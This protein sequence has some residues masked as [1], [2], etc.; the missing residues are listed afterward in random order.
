MEVIQLGSFTLQWSMLVLLVS[1]VFGIVAIALRLKMENVP[2]KPWTEWAGTILVCILLNEK[3]GYLWDSPSIIWNQTKAL[4]FLSGTSVNGNVLLGIGL[5][6]WTITYIR[7]HQLSYGLLSDVA[8]HGLLMGLAVYGFM[9][10]YSGTPAPYLTPLPLPAV[11]AVALPP[12]E[13]IMSL[14]LLLGLWLRK[15]EMGSYAD[16]QLSALAAGVI[17][18]LMSY[19]YPDDERMFGLSIL[20]WVSVALLAASYFITR[21]CERVE[22]VRVQSETTIEDFPRPLGEQEAA[23]G[24]SGKIG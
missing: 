1:F 9:Y 19:M 7:K 20:Q 10:A 13:S 21:A 22:A 16:A 17:G 5:V 15:R 8:A 12:F 24:N 14:L 11:M 2:V 4:L 23:D 6:A 3:F 18:M